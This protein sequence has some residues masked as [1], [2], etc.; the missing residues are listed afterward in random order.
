MISDIYKVEGKYPDPHE[1][2]QEILNAQSEE[3]YNRILSEISDSGLAS[4]PLLSRFFSR[5]FQ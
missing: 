3:E 2:E 5:S 4:H 1:I